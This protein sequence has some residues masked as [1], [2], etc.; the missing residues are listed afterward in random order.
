MDTENNLIGSSLNGFE[1][2]ELIGRGGMGV[3]YKARDTKLDRLVA[4]KLMDPLLARDAAF[5]KR[6]WSE[7]KAL[8]RLQNPYIVGVY[9]L[10]ETEQG[11]CIVMEYVKGGTLADIIKEIGPLPPQRALKLFGQ[12]LQAFEH[13]HGAGIIHRDVKPGNIMVT[14]EDVVKVTDFGLAKIFQASS[15]TVTSLSGGT[16][17]YASPE[18]I[19]GLGKVDQRGDIYSIGMT[20]YEALAGVVPFG[21][22]ESDFAIREKIVRGKIPPP[23]SL[24][25]NLPQ[26]LN[27]VVVK[28]IQKDPA[29]RFQSATEMR[30]A[31]EKVSFPR[32]QPAP[33]ATTARQ[34][35]KKT[36][37]LPYA[38]GVLALVVLVGAGYFLMPVLFPEDGTL[39]IHS[40]PVGATVEV[41]GTAVGE[42]PLRNLDTKAGRVTVRVSKPDYIPVDTLLFL[43]KG[44]SAVLS[45]NLAQAAGETSALQGS[46]VAQ[47]IETGPPARR[48]VPPTQPPETRTGG[49]SKEQLARE[50]A[51]SGTVKQVATA[52]KT[53]SRPPA[54]RETVTTGRCELVVDSNPPG[55]TVWVDQTRVDR[56]PY[57]V[58]AGEHVVRVVAGAQEWSKRV[59]FQ[60]GGSVKIPVDFSKH[61]SISITAFDAEGKGVR[62]KIYVDGVQVLHSTPAEV[63]LPIGLH[64]FAVQRD[65]YEQVPPEIRN[66][67]SD[68]K[69]AS[70]LKF[71][72]RQSAAK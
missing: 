4:I 47:K 37:L 5:M 10:L 18:Q 61:V 16:L 71:I 30:R 48:T 65:G 34:A 27:A 3:V 38:I 39:S 57:P 52:T 53:P 19:E 59:T 50:K 41:N 44:E 56:M 49:K 62:A 45:L 17:F 64:T 6:F 43:G 70:A 8:A 42:T 21:N 11:V 46:E 40:T 15:A 28:A 51:A 31:L 67:E 22:S 58:A 20:L 35:P 24:R 63:V 69:G 33:S 1:I 25:P 36:N 55:A 14:P 13:A 66:V 2:V 68:L 23:K 54:G 7:A 12:L 32:A 9:S 29:Q 72:M 60:A 26:E